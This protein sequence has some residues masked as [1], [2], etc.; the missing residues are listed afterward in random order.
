MS[1]SCGFYVSPLEWNICAFGNYPYAN[2]VVCVI[3]GTYLCVYFRQNTIWRWLLFN[4]WTAWAAYQLDQIQQAYF[5]L[6]SSPMQNNPLITRTIAPLCILLWSLSELGDTIL[7][8]KRYLIIKQTPVETWFKTSFLTFLTLAVGARLYHIGI[9]I[10][11]GG[12]LG[13]THSPGFHYVEP[14]YF[15]FVLICEVLVQGR[16]LESLL[17]MRGV[18]RGKL[19]WVL[20][21]GAGARMGFITVPLAARIIYQFTSTTTGLPMYQWIWTFTAAVNLFTMIDLLM[22]KYE[23]AAGQNRRDRTPVLPPKAQLNKGK[24][25]AGGRWRGRNGLWWR[26]RGANPSRKAG[27]MPSLVMTGGQSGRVRSGGGGGGGEGAGVPDT[28]S[29]PSLLM[30]RQ[31]DPAADAESLPPLDM[32]SSGQELWSHERDRGDFWVDYEEDG[33][34]TVDHIPGSELLSGENSVVRSADRT[35]RE[36]SVSSSG[37]GW[38]ERRPRSETSSRR[39]WRSGHERVGTEG[40]W[41][42]GDGYMGNEPSFTPLDTDTSDQRARSTSIRSSIRNVKHRVDEPGPS[43]PQTPPRHITPER[44]RPTFFAP[45]T[46]AWN[47]SPGRRRGDLESGLGGLSPS[48]SP[49]RQSLARPGNEWGAHVDRRSPPPM[50][51]NT[52]WVKAVMSVPPT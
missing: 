30:G 21:K 27:S 22:L 38:D 10:R 45:P 28:K 40:S 46:M 41:R 13:V 35:E 24:G 50:D 29:P 52:E 39:S 47:G 11:D 19:V 2:S 43:Y 23:L 9:V 5:Y 1:K 15:L 34:F 14:T 12:T 8:Y 31:S 25:K 44:E 17:R 36:R 20:L 4:V 32:T 42:G 51:V 3:L 7:F 33:E 6:P 16:Y 37:G 18:A 48:R 49:P 26:G